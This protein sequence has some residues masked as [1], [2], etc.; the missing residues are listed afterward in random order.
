MAENQIT[1]L[2]KRIKELEN[3]NHLL[4]EKFNFLTRKLVGRTTEQTSSLSIEGQMSLLDEAEI[5]ANS[6]AT[7][8]DLNEVASYKH[9]R[10]KVQK[11]ELLIDIPHKKALY[12]SRRRPFLSGMW[13]TISFGMRGIRQNRNRNLYQPRYV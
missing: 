6:N 10:F 8:P 4:Q 7:E 12:T 2:K 5:S 9:K 3:E 13:Y 11:E 1:F